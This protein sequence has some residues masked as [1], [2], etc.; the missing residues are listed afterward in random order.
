MAYVH[1]D[2][3]SK[4]RNKILNDFREGKIEILISTTIIA[5]GKNFPLL[6]SMINASGFKAEEKTIQFLGRLVRLHKSKSKAYLDDIQYPGYYLGKHSRARIR[7][8]KKQ[9][10]KV[11][12][13]NK[14]TKY[15]IP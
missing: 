6:K 7:A 13:I 4:K 5:R 2:T 3:P 9:G 14:P 10:Y 11:I 1:V 12:L 15:H 8:Y